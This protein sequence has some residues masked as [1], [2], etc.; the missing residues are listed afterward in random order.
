MK[1]INEAKEYISSIIGDGYKHG[2]ILG[3]G[4]NNFAD[5]LE[6]KIYIPYEKIPGFV[7]STAP[8]HKGQLVAGTLKNIKI[9][10]LQGR[11]HFYEGYSMEQ[12]IFPTRVF[13][14]LGIE[15]LIVTNASGSLNIDMKPGDIVMLKDHINFMGTNPLIGKNNEELGPRFVSMHDTYCREYREKINQYARKRDIKIQ[16]G[17]YIAVSGPSFETISECKFFATIGADVVGMSTVPEVI[18][19]IHCGIKVL[20]FSVV[21]NYSNIF[22]S[23]IHSQDEI[24]E[25]ADK[26]SKNL[27]LLVSDFI[28]ENI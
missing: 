10:I 25:N 12:I 13:K 27:E 23:N 14:A 18:A 8:S 1:T 28:T 2:V 5:C 3:T 9:V 4:L 21:T 26:A 16:E 22:H 6:N 19:A 17:V 11:F 7:S 20:A 24:R 15:N